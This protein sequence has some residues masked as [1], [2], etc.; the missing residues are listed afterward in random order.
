M[1]INNKL[2][3]PLT[4]SIVALAAIL[5]SPA[6]KKN[7]VENRNL[8]QAPTLV[9]NAV[10]PDAPLCGAIKGTMLSGYTYTIGCDV[11]V[12]AGDTL[13]IQPGVTINVTRGYG[14]YVQGSLF[15]L[16]TQTQPV[17]MTVKGAVKQ[18]NP[19]VSWAADSALTGL[20]TGITADVNCPWL[21]LK[22]THIEF[23]GN[24]YSK[25]APSVTGASPGSK[26][27]AILFQNPLGYFIME[28]SWLYGS[29]DDA[30]RVNGG[31]LSVMRNTFEKT[32]STGG[33]S[34]NMKAGTVGD[35]AYNVFVGS[36]TNG[37]KASNKGVSTIQCNVNMYNNTYIDCGYRQSSPGGRGASID[38]EEGA[39]GYA[40]NNLI[41]DCRIG[42]RIVNIPPADTINM[43]YGNTYNYGDSLAITN[44]FYPTAYITHPEPTD[45]PAPSSFL[46]ANYTLGAVYNGSSVVSK[47]NPLFVNF[48]LPQYLYHQY[49]FSGSY[50]FTL[51]PASPAIGK[52][53]TGFAP[54]A[55]VPVDAK[56]GATQI[57]YPGKD[58]GAFQSNGTGNLHF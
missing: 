32:G 58:I 23:A 13:T 41:V 30:I 48:P 33:E 17:Y 18:D 43:H 50:N 39:R 52:G 27:Y 5:I 21:V 4:I 22:W 37:S 38:Y 12:N 31:K 36:A 55:V 8:Y 14:I 11:I 46:P 15:S 57:T 9:A 24:K 54:L 35:V 51:Q 28:D 16:G 56:Y 1:K 45:I 19:S 40:Y 53:Y 29:T 2:I 49:D 25:N 47:N 44:Q 26:A 7:H 3:L 10:S 34:L 20:W 42:L 6:C